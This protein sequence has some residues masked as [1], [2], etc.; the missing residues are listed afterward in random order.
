MPVSEKTYQQ[1]ALEDPSGRWEL[2]CGELRRKPGM[3]M[4]HNH[5]QDKLARRLHAQLDEAHYRLRT[6]ASRAEVSDTTYFVPDLFVIPAELERA[7]RGQPQTLETYSEPLPLV[8]EVWSRS[9]GEYDVMSKLPE[10]Q[11]RG[12]L[13]IWLVHPYEHTITAW[14]RQPDGSYAESFHEA[15]A[16]EPAH[17]PGVRIDLADLFAFD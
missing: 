11:R 16:I 10:Y 3:T 6:D 17:F 1:V 9:T 15:G 14:R 2:Y 12:D 4:E 5:V 13:E 8:V 7:R